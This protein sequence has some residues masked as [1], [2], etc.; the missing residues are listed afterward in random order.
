MA[1]LP[2]RPRTGSRK[3]ITRKAPLPLMRLS[4]SAKG[5][6]EKGQ[7]KPTVFPVAL[8]AGQSNV[9]ESFFRRRVRRKNTDTPAALGGDTSSQT[10]GGG[11]KGGACSPFI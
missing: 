10:G 6:K 8:P 11:S 2:A 4:P 7:E 1:R 5:A 9:P 3:S